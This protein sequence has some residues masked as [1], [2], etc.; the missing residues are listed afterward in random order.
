MDFGVV[1]SLDHMNKAAM[2]ICVQ[3]VWMCVFISPGWITVS[4]VAGSCGE[5]ESFQLFSKM[6]EPFNIPSSMFHLFHILT[7][8]R[9]YQSF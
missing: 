7:S 6:A 1:P 8:P 4:A 9:Y 2:S 5:W 3:V